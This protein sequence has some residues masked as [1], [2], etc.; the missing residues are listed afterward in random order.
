MASLVADG[1]TLGSDEVVVVDPLTLD[2][3]PFARGI[4]VK[5]LPQPPWRR[6]RRCWPM[7]RT[8]GLAAK[9]SGISVPPTEAGCRRQ[10]RS[11]RSWYPAAR[12]GAADPAGSLC[13]FGDLTDLAGAVVQRA[14]ARRF[15]IETLTMLQQVD[16]YRL[17]LSSLDEATALLQ[18]PSRLNSSPRG[19]GISVSG[20]RLDGASWSLARLRGSAWRSRR[21]SRRL[22]TAWRCSISTPRSCERRGAAARPGGKSSAR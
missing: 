10:R 5:G 8:T 4:C 13:P 14:E 2:V 6:T 1:F 3:L 19:R 20:P 15:G 18:R 17:T 9:R 7:R 21:G 22:A 12:P 11:A 16:C